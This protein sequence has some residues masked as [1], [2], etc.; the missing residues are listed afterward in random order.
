MS[1]AELDVSVVVLDLLR[2]AHAPDQQRIR[3]Q[4]QLPGEQ[5]LP[6]ALD[7]QILPGTGLGDLHAEVFV[8]PGL[9]DVDRQIRGVVAVVVNLQHL[10]PVQLLV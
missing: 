3:L 2:V 8:V 10:P 9:A 4:H 6:E 7:G 1:L 5:Q